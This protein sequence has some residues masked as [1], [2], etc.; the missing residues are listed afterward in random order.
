MDE[1]ETSNVSKI[2]IRKTVELTQELEKMVVCEGVE[3]E[4]QASY[5]KA[6]HCDMAQGYLYAKPMSMEEFEELVD[7]QDTVA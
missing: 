6:I 3:T 2:I 4:E 5:L 1:T 7:S